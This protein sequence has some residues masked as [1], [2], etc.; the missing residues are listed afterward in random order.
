MIDDPKQGAVLGINAYKIE[1]F[2][3]RDKSRGASVIS[4][5]ETV[6]IGKVEVKEE[7]LTVNLLTIYDKADTANITDKELKD[8]IKAFHE[9]E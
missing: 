1:D 2:Q 3:Q 4:L 6:L 9:T 7:G 5:V 8:L